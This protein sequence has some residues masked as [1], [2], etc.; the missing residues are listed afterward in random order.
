MYKEFGIKENI[1]NLANEVEK[2]IKPIFEE[3]DKTSEENSL[4]VLHA[5]CKNNISDMH[6]N[7]T[8]GYGYG[9]VRKRCNRK[10]ICRSARSRR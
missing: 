9:D 4:K 3:I 8:T 10:N 6:F 5:F 7:S 1:I 2:E